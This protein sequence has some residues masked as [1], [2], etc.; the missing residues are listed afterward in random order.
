MM[1]KVGASAGW[2]G[3][4]V[5][6]ITTTKQLTRGDSGKVFMVDNTSAFTI[7]LPDLSSK[8]AGWTCKMIVQVNGAQDVS[9]LAYGLPAAGGTTAV[10]DDAEQ[11]MY[12]EHA[13]SEAGTMAQ[14]KDG[15]T[16]EGASSIGD[17]WEIFSDGTTWFVNAFV[18]DA[19]HSGTIDTD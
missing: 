18:M 14:G 4:Y 9:V 10:S 8:L 15:F 12:R 5:E 11:V 19:D 7:N 1:A 2:T 3:N 6:T 16:I 13:I 17:Y